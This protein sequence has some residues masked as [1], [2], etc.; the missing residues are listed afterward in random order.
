MA[1]DTRKWSHAFSIAF[2]VESTEAYGKDVP[3]HEITTAL[4]RTIVRMIED[5]TDK[6]QCE[7]FDTIEVGT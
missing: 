2:E 1:K 6:D 5:K 4:L 3:P 7:C